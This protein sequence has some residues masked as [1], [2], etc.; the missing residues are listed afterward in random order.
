[1]EE[2]KIAVVSF[3]A[4][5]CLAAGGVSFAFLLFFIWGLQTD[6]LG[7]TWLMRQNPFA[8]AAVGGAA[9]ITAQAL[10]VGARKLSQTGSWRA[11]QAWLKWWT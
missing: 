2:F 6:P 3:A 4:Y 5:L 7:V 11:Y 10:E 1:M 9:M 8:I